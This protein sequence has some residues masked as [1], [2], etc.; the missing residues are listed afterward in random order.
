LA[1]RLLHES[2]RKW[3]SGAQSL[4][5]VMMMILEFA[6]CRSSFCKGLYLLLAGAGLS[7][8][9]AKMHKNV[10]ILDTHPAPFYYWIIE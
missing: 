5:K 6:C 10:T 9:C 2:R 1:A 3:G 8:A 7:L 4:K